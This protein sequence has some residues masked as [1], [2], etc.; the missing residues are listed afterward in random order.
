MHLISE[1]DRSLSSRPAYRTSSRT[2]RDVTQR[3]PV[4]KKE[5]EGGGEWRGGREGRTK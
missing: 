3:T 5:R 1:A 4:S 2:A